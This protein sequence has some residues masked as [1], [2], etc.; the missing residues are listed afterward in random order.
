MISHFH[1]QFYVCV[2]LFLFVAYA[3]IQDDDEQHN[4]SPYNK[5]QQ[6]GPM[7]SLELSLRYPTGVHVGMDPDTGHFMDD[8]HGYEH[9]EHDHGGQ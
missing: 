9:D 5:E 2:N 7:G 8:D 3:T 1:S 4:T 6:G